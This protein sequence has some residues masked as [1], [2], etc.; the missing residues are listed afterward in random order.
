MGSS[1]LTS[2]YVAHVTESTWRVATGVVAD[3]PPVVVG[4]S[5]VVSALP[6]A[7]VVGAATAAVPGEDAAVSFLSLPEQLLAAVAATRRRAVSRRVRWVMP[8]SL[9][10]LLMWLRRTS[11][12]ALPARPAG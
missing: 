6:P 1:E 9:S 12:P 4:A 3:G 5:A 2:R 7:A 11:W 10:W 8:F